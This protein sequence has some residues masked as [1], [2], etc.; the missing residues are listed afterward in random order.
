MYSRDELSKYEY[1]KQVLA[2]NRLSDVLDPLTG[3]V[4]RTHLINFLS[5][6]A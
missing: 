3:L 6:S 5:P 4:N 1:F 2:M